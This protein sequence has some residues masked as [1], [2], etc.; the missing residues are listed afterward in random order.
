MT[1][2]TEPGGYRP[3]SAV[4]RHQEPAA[5]PPPTQ[6]HSGAHACL[7]EVVDQRLQRPRPLGRSI[8]PLPSWQG[9]TELEGGHGCLPP[10]PG[11]RVLHQTRSFIEKTEERGPTPV[12]IKSGAPQLA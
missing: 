3:D 4:L 10:S 1:W 2:K 9:T 7:P 12:S 8:H 5:P 11:P 6:T